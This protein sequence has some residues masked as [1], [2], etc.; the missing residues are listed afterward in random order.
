MELDMLKSIQ[1]E[2]VQQ[3]LEGKQRE[4]PTFNY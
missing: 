3:L 2:Y 4:K 1:D